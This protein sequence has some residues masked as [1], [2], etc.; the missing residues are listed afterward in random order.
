M[1]MR[2]TD[3]SNVLLINE[4]K[5]D[6]LLLSVGISE[7]LPKA[8]IKSFPDITSAE[9]YLS[10]VMFSAEYYA[11]PPDIIFL[12]MPSQADRILKTLSLLEKSGHIQN[13]RLIV[14]T[15]NGLCRP[16]CFARGA[17]ECYDK[18]KTIDELITLLEKILDT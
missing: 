13:S 12:S 7:L 1:C 6:E 5:M 8:L 14:F 10:D 17:N 15:E 18:P 4:A 11:G 16:M 3:A 9:N 2:I